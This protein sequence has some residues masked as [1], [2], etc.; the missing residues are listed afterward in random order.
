[1]LVLALRRVTRPQVSSLAHRTVILPNC[2]IAIDNV[3]SWM[4]LVQPRDSYYLV[5]TCRG[6]RVCFRVLR[7]SI[8]IRTF[9]LQV[10]KT[11]PRRT[12]AT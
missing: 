6:G 11:S 4:L 1:M 3:P 2:L 9:N 5:L 12:R 7:T 10:R 8:V